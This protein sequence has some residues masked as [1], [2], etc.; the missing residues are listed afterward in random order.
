MSDNPRPAP[1]SAERIQAILDGSPFIRFCG[2]RVAA[3]DH[4]AG[5][6]ALAME[7]RPELERRSGTGQWHGGALAGLIDTAGD[8]AVAMGLGAV[9]PTINFRVDYLRPAMTPRLTA[10]ATVRR[11]GRTVA[12]VDIDV[13]D[14]DGR[15]VAVGRGCYG[16]QP[17]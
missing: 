10:T 15:L 7:L 1:L 17:G 11:S 13:T 9:V 14:A 16:A 4:A 2:M 5:K 12:V 6:L 8:F 3:L